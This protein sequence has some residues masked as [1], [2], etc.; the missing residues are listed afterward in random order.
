MLLH[1][2]SSVLGKSTEKSCDFSAVI[3]APAAPNFTEPLTSSF[4][5]GVVVPIIAYR[6]H[7]WRGH[8]QPSGKWRT[9]KKTVTK[10][11]DVADVGG[12]VSKRYVCSSW[13]RDSTEPTS[14]SAFQRHQPL[15]YQ[16]YRKNRYVSSRSPWFWL[17]TPIEPTPS[18]RC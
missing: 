12:R 10:L 15:C 9:S 2:P 1:V 3:T 17:V 6:S 14:S 18:R 4:A 5:V 8:R 16:S 11:N 13:G 7:V